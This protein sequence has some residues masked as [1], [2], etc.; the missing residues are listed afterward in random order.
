MAYIQIPRDFSKVKTKVMFNLTK[1]QLCCFSLAAAAGVPTYLVTR[2]V[3]GNDLAV[4][5]MIGLMLPFFFFAMFER[6]GQPAEVIL[7]NYARARLWPGV[8]PYK[9]QNLYNYL[10]EEGSF[11]AHKNKAPGRV[12][13]RRNNSGKKR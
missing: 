10:H 3:V 6:D 13:A 5:L 2:Q 4:L 1:R 7:R 12:P 8:R 9:N 11:I